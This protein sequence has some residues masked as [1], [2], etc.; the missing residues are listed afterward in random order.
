MRKQTTTIKTVLA[1][2]VI[3]AISAVINN[4][5]SAELNTSDFQ[6][7]IHM[8]DL[9]N[10]YTYSGISA[11]LTN[12]QY[13]LED[14]DTIRLVIQDTNYYAVYNNGY[15]NTFTFSGIYENGA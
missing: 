6:Y 5:V 11:V 13:S 2:S 4:P 1:M 12:G 3:I 15:N 8:T 7:S 9:I 14:Q 10:Y